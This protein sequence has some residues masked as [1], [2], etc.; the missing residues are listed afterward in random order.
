MVKVRKPFNDGLHS[1]LKKDLFWENSEFQNY[2]T[3][4][5]NQATDYVMTFQVTN[6]KNLFHF[7]FLSY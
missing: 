1:K 7:I 5:Q 2:K 6:L 4:S 3:E